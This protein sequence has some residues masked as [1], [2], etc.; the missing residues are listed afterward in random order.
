M[1]RCFDGLPPRKRGVNYFSD[2]PYLGDTLFAIPTSVKNK[3]ER[4]KA[5]EIESGKNIFGGMERQAFSTI[6][7]SIEFGGMSERNKFQEI[8][9]IFS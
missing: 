5:E 1:H 2:G 6:N 7:Q 8:P 3:L 9:S 4:E